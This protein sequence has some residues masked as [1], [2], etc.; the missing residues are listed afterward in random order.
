M[1]QQTIYLVDD[2]EDDRFLIR[3][4]VTGIIDNV[5]VIEFENGVDFL[6]QIRQPD[7][8]L[9]STLIILDINMPRLSGLEVITMLRSEQAGR[10][11]PIVAIS[12]ASDEWLVSQVLSCGASRFFTKPE[13]LNG[14][15]QLANTVRD[16]LNEFNLT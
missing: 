8:D 1:N 15:Q 13:T 16:C 11:L 12:T 3:E 7:L 4:A 9:K 10:N 2:D 6:D 14:M 5:Q